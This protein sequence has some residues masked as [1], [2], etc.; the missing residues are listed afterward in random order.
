MNAMRNLFCLLLPLTLAAQEVPP[1]EGLGLDLR[2]ELG[3][4][5]T[6]RIHLI[7]SGCWDGLLLSPAA[8]QTVRMW[9]RRRAEATVEVWD[10]A[11]QESLGNRT[12]H[13]FFEDLRS[14]L[15]R[16]FASPPASHGAI[17]LSQFMLSDP[18]NPQQT[19]LNTVRSLQDRYNRLPPNGSPVR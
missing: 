7:T 11:F 14:R 2:R 1:G 12:F 19:N 3:S 10:V 4:D 16:A 6:T 18:A 15:L 9:Q 8:P 13:L 17:E 5:P